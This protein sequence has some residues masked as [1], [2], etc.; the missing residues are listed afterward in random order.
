MQNA[1]SHIGNALLG[2]EPYG[3]YFGENWVSVDPAVD[4]DETREEI[5]R[6]VDGYP[7]IFRDV[8]TYLKERIRE[9]LTGSSD[10][11][12]IRVSGTDLETIRAKAV[13]IN[14][15]IAGIPGVV[16]NHVDFQTTIPQIEVKV[17]LDAAKEYGVKPGDVR[18]AA[19]WMMAGEEA[20]DVYQGGRAY[21]VQLWTAPEKRTSLTD[22]KNLPIDTPS[23]RS[24]Q[25]HR[26]G[27]GGGRPG[28]ERDPPRGPVPEHRRGRQHRRLA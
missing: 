8:L 16:E 21:D 26:C 5:Q 20:G 17:N 7:G 13:E 12:T 22:L 1:G 14:D 18:R 28:A 4:Y 11:I 27:I 2:D 3:V 6:V 25:A 9:V 10:A 24:G 19:A 15:K 23:R